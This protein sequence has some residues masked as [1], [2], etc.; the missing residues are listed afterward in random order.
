MNIKKYLSLGIYTSL[1]LLLASIVLIIL[2]LLKP[3]DIKNTYVFDIKQ[4]DSLYKVS[5]NLYNNN[6]IQ[7]P[8]ILRI[9]TYIFRIDNK[10]KS[11]EYELNQGDRIYDLINKITNG[12]V[13]LYSL[14]IIEGENLG[15]I[16]TKLIR[17]KK[18]KHNI[19]ADFDNINNFNS[20]E[21]KDYI[22]KKSDKLILEYLKKISTN[23][24]SNIDKA[25]NYKNNFLINLE[26]IT[27]SEGLLYPDTYFY[28][29]GM[30]DDEIIKQSYI[31][32]NDKVNQYW[33]HF[34]KNANDK[35]NIDNPIDSPYKAL[36]V[37]SI[38]EK[39]SSDYH[40]RELVSGV[41]Y[42]RLNNNMRLQVDPT[43][44]YAMG[45]NFSGN[46]KKEDLSVKSPYNTYVNKG[47]P[48]TPICFVS[49]ESLK[50][51][52]N[53]VRHDLLYFVSMGNGKHHFSSTL[54]KHN[55][56]V[57]EY[58]KS[59]NNQSNKEEKK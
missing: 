47:L 57:G 36:I 34:I 55:Q 30:S 40:D 26:N 4:G 33:Q 35:K 20:L 12:N 54:E 37:A 2:Y 41:I 25:G 42:N 24:A 22:I 39:E 51:A 44:I 11:G 1:I 8:K 31:K 7:Y 9:F 17:S 59:N 15:G 18:L 28:T 23:N 45:S 5:E 13:R 27:S 38:L 16:V 3:I 46:L 53:P 50:A 14:T 29:K 56:A 32:L 10:I 21:E 6:I 58:Q 52:L 43:V 19:L 48:P 49:D